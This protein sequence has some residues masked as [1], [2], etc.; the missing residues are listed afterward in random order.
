MKAL[1][2]VMFACC[3]IWLCAPAATAGD[4][5]GSAVKS[6]P[7]LKTQVD[8]AGRRT[9]YPSHKPAEMSALLVEI[10]PGKET[11][12]HIHTEPS[13]AYILE[14][15][16]TVEWEDGSTRVI[17]AGEAFAEV[18]KLKHNGRNAGKI[19]VKLVMFVAGSKDTPVAEKK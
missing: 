6:R 7:L 3:G 16:V 19:P 12:W 9:E 15:E 13:M 17:K 14:G 2:S 1:L 18:V 8:A 11:G 4:A 10:P 5:Y